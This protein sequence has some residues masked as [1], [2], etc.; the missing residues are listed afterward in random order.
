MQKNNKI[1]NLIKEA[2]KNLNDLID[3]NAIIGK[4]ID[5]EDG[6]IIIPISKV[7]LG[8]ISGGGE[9]G[10]KD[11]SNI[12]ADYP[13]SGA[14][15]AVVSLKPSGFLVNK[16]DGYKLIQVPGDIYEKILTKAEDFIAT[17]KQD[18]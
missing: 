5:T 8:Y 3:V 16:G 13:F 18:N 2:I 10:E 6:T 1:E 17:F 12:Y 7:T 14:S 15:G 11:K 4:P 9:Y